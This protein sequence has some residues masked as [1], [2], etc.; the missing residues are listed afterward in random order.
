MASPEIIESLKRCELFS[1]IADEDIMHIADICSFENFN[2]GETVIS[3]GAFSSQI[4]LITEGQV[5]LIR[6]V[7]LGDRQGTATVDVLGKGRGFG[8][9]CILCD[10]CGASASALCQKPST[11]IALP[12]SELRGLLEKKP[13]LGFTVMERLAQIIANRLRAAYGAMDTLR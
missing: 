9:S 12:G 5:A 10:P 11:L 1:T 6:S 2:A 3:Q 4:Y 7:N 8:W 13:Q